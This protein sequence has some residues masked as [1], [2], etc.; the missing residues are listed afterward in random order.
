MEP[1]NPSFGIKISTVDQTGNITVG[2]I[3]AARSA[4][5]LLKQRTSLNTADVVNRAIVVY[6]FIELET[7][8]KGK[9]LL[10]RDASGQEETITFTTGAK[11]P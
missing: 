2:L 1:T 3:Q 4:L 8:N 10:L 9:T 7:V 5:A 11:R 6:D